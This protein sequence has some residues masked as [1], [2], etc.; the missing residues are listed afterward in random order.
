M[1]GLPTA[2]VDASMAEK[3]DHMLDNFLDRVDRAGIKGI[4]IDH[5]QSSRPAWSCTTG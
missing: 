3:R 1:S 4:M 2:P 5:V